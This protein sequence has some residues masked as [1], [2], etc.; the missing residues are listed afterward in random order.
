MQLSLAQ[1]AEMIASSVPVSP[2]TMVAG[3]SIDSRTIRPRELFF[4]VKGQRLDGH[5]FVSEV[6]GAGAAGAVVAASSRGNFPAALQSKLLAVPDPLAA[7]QALAAGVRRRWGGPVVAITGSTGKTT[8]KQIIASL[9]RTNFRVL[10]NAGNLNNQFGLPLSLLRLESETEIGVFEMGMSGPGEIRLLANIAEPHVAVVTNVSAAHLQF[11]PNVQ[12]I[13]RAKFELME[14]LGP[15]DWAVLN[16]DDPRVASFGVHCRSHVLYFGLGDSADLRADE[17]LPSTDGGYSFRVHLPVRGEIRPASAWKDQPA[18]APLTS[19]PSDVRFHLPLIG[20]HN[21]SN[22]LAALGV[23][24]LFGI[25]PASL[26]EA[27]SRLEPASQ[28]GELVRLANGVR[29]VNDCYNSNPGALEA[30]LG[31]VA[32]IPAGRRYAVLGGMRELGPTSEQLHYRCGRRVVELGFAGLITVGDE[33]RP[34][35]AGALAAGIPDAAVMHC[36]TPEEAGER[37]REMFEPGDVVLLKASRAVQLEKIWDRLGP[38]ADVAP[39]EVAAGAGSRRRRE[40]T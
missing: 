29:I 24:Y 36:A 10:E 33:A 30:M 38:R 27:V 1:I 23:A 32:E 11:F 8:T 2:E 14:A 7:L 39:E 34:L 18:V 9:L 28:R 37:L 15:G 20:R 40:G 16:T 3:Y 17:L 26:A 21:V 19:S 12:A 25:K 6:L 35:A 13:A 22:V 4:A 5:A 31:A